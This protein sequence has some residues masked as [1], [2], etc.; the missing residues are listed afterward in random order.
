MRI[1]FRKTAY[2]I[3]FKGKN[4]LPLFMLIKEWYTENNEAYMAKVL[5]QIDGKEFR[6]LIKNL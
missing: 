4:Q 5:F 3:G 1:N 2:N 6:K